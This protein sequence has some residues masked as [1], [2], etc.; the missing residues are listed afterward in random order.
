MHVK[1]IVKVTHKKITF[2]EIFLSL[3][4]MK[5]EY[6][7]NFCLDVKFK[8]FTVKVTQCNKISFFAT[9]AVD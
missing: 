9:F 1:F 4:G 8:K 7:I 6:L 2:S 3:K 5:S